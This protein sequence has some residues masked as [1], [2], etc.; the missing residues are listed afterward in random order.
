MKSLKPKPSRPR[1]AAAAPRA[2]SKAPRRTRTTRALAASV[3]ALLAVALLAVASA[4]SASRVAARR[5]L[6][7]SPSPNSPHSTSVEVAAAR[8][9]GVNTGGA[10]AAAGAPL[11]ARAAAPLSLFFQELPETVETFAQDCET[12]KTS[13]ELGET[14]CAKATNAVVG[15]SPFFGIFPL[16]KF[17]LINPAGFQV[18]S[19]PISAATQTHSFTLPAEATVTIGEQVFDNR[20]PWRVQLSSIFENFQRA[21]ASFTVR[22]PDNAAVDLSVSTTQEQQQESIQ[23]GAQAPFLII[24][25][26]KGPDAA[27]DFELRNPVPDNTTFFS[28]TQSEGLEFEFECVNPNVGTGPSGTSVCSIESLPAGARATFVAVYLVGGGTEP[29]TEIVNSP[30]VA[31][32]TTERHQPD[33]SA[34]AFYVVSEQARCTI[35]PPADVTVDNDIVG[36]VAQG[37][38]VVSYGAPTSQGDCGPVSCEPASNSFF[39]VGETSV[40]CTNV[41]QDVFERFT[42][43]VNDTRTPTISCPANFTVEE[44]SPG[45]GEAVVNFPAPTVSDNDPNIQITFDPPSGAPLPI[46]AHTVTATA[47]DASGNFASCQFTVTVVE[48]AGACTITPDVANLPTITGECTVSVSTVPTATDSCAGR[49]GA[50]TEDPR[51]YDE[52][53]TYVV[54]WTYTNAGGTTVTQNQNVVVTAGSGVLG[55]TGPPAVSVLNPAGSASCFVHVVDLGAVL[56]TTV[57]GSCTNTDVTR[58]VSPPAPDNDFQVGTVYT[59]VST[60]TDGTNSA[61]VTQTLRVF[62]DT[63]P[64]VTAPAD[65]TYEC[66]ASVPAAD[67]SQA[68]AAD[69]CGTPTVTV[70]E[71]TNGGA[72]S[73]ASPLVITRTYTATDSS[74]SGRTATDSQV[75]TVTDST[76]PAISAPADVTVDADPVACAV[77]AAGVTLGAPTVNDNCATTVTNNAP[78]VYQLGQTTVTWTATDAAG[79]TATATQRVNVVDVTAPVITINGPA[80]V[81]VECHTSYA[82]AGATAADACDPNV[83]V[84][85]SG[86]VDVN[87]PGVYTITYTAEDDAGNDAAPVTRTINVVDTIAAT[88]TLTGQVITLWPPNHQYRT[89]NVSDLVAGAS[90]GCDTTIGLDDVFIKQVTSDES[91]NG[92][93]DGNTS[94]DIVIGANCKSMQLRAERN[95]GGNGRVYTITFRVRDASG[96]E[97]TATAQVYVPKNN[98]GTVVDNGPAQTVTS[99]CP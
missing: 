93:G 71:T 43:T 57:T 21:S 61:S 67:P 31:S 39:P 95:G 63:P 96:N 51:F 6:E 4:A 64:T 53:G 66:A 88:I 8:R 77:A 35:T 33:N 52:P 92:N 98:N 76:P 3:V 7:G 59:V 72:G 87:T 94:N 58:V 73:A 70:S 13:F 56:N 81:V 75:I 10:A 85:A 37:G 68:M 29:K 12:P 55:I 79:N 24:V 2:R 18:D 34:E 83:P 48:R 11:A 47:T 65:A 46:G 60:V 86:V 19:S 23:A 90:D 91:D 84:T 82:D 28:L 20:G 26:N 27:A 69:N 42:V 30:T 89:V 15:S 99:G 36:G 25:E 62:D 5:S 22:D 54:R 38:A 50:T 32:A 78:S 40:T 17:S 80:T 44:S 97:R 49:V 1:D 16:R 74:G 41:R 14:V 45:A 9:D